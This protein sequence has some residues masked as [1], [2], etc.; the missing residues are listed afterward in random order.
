MS[1]MSAKMTRVGGMKARMS[2]VCGTNATFL[3]L[4]DRDGNFILTVD[5]KYI[6]VKQTN[7]NNG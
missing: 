7:N 4:V 5:G 6:L 1:C 2:L 3:R